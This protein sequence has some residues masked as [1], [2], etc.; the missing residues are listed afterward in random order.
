[1]R[2][3]AFCRGAR[4]FEFGNLLECG[5]E[6]STSIADGRFMSIGLLAKLVDG[7]LGT[8]NVRAQLLQ[9]NTVCIE[10]QDGLFHELAEAL[11]LTIQFRQAR[12]GGFHALF[13]FAATLLESDDFRHQ[14]RCSFDLCGVRRFGLGGAPRQRLLRFSRIAKPVLRLRQ[15]RI[16]RPLFLIEA[17]NRLAGLALTRVEPVSLLFRA[18]ALDG[19]ELCLFG[20][21]LR[22]SDDRCSCISRARIAFSSLCRSPFTAA[23]ALET[24]TTRVSS[25]ATSVTD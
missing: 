6:D 20:D 15:S 16:S 22:S 12:L 8:P 5:I 24:C 3:V 9:P 2:H 4:H 10:Q 13:E 25:A 21:F 7:V 17:G 19:D 23:S 14:R 11:A 1:M 18:P